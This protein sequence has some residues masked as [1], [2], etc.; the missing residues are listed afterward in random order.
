[1]IISTILQAVFVL[2]LVANTY[3]LIKIVATQNKLTKVQDRIINAEKE[4]LEFIR[5]FVEG[6]KELA[7]EREKI[8]KEKYEQEKEVMGKELE[9]KEQELEATTQTAEQTKRTIKTAINDMINLVSLIYRIS[10]FMGAPPIIE[11]YINQM[12][13]SKLAKEEALKAFNKAREET[14]EL[15]ISALTAA[16]LGPTGPSR[17]K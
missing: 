9:A 8:L 6:L 4:D 5:S 11:Q 15:G 3:F 2:L 12:Q 1:M 7:Q 14:K 17:E 10:L 16:L 13:A